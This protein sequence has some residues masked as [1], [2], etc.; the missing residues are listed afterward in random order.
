MPS[1]T[2]DCGLPERLDVSL[3]EGES[4]RPSYVGPGSSGLV[5]RGRRGRPYRLM[6][7]RTGRTGGRSPSSRRANDCP[8]ERRTR[9]AEQVGRTP[10]A[11]NLAPIRRAE[12][13]NLHGQEVFLV[14][15]G[16]DEAHSLPRMLERSE[17]LQRL[18]HVF[19]ALPWLEQWWHGLYYGLCPLPADL[20][21][22]AS[23]QVHL[24]WLPEWRPPDLES[25]FD[26][27]AR[28]SYLSPDYV[29][30]IPDPGLLRSLDVYALGYL[31]YQ[32]LYRV[33]P[34]TDGPSVLRQKLTG[35]LSRAERRVPFW[36]EWLP[37]FEEIEA[38]IRHM[39]SSDP[40]RRSAVDLGS[41]YA[42]FLDVRSR[43][44]LEG[45]VAAVKERYGVAV[46]YLYLH[47]IMTSENEYDVYLRGAR[48]CTLQL[49][50]PASAIDAYESAIALD[51]GR[52]DAFELEFRLI[53]SEKARGALE[54]I[55]ENNPDGGTSID[56]KMRRN[57]ARLGA[58]ARREDDQ[59]SWCHF[60]LWRHPETA[61]T[62]A[63]ERLLDHEENGRWSF[64][65]R[66]LYAE[67][68]I[69]IDQME[70]SR[71]ELDRI[72]RD[73]MRAHRDAAVP[74]ALLRAHGRRFNELDARWK[75]RFQARV[76]TR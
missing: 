8:I 34:P 2:P 35:S 62:Y 56:A 57:Y 10:P 76:V 1:T 4:R 44:N 69:A 17:P 39:V 24:L 74:A 20:V 3:A 58:F 22:D 38:E 65:W 51:P 19:N 67:A 16:L 30:G 26:Q 66:L 63:Y 21:L 72:Q 18:G 25:V 53:A 29:R 27:P 37:E 61:A 50:L 14:E 71:A 73:F 31:L 55:I 7:I 40:A 23:H 5:Y 64:W 15:Y 59:L 36:F 28:G 75:S 13:L 48:S 46:A 12:T 9:I 45:V 32:C 54:R 42:K 68:L 47:R 11:R 6:P 49:N 60:L 33:E 41:F 70:G 43:L 52:E